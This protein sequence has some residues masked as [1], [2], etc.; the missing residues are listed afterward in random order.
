MP[1]VTPG[2]SSSGLT[3]GFIA[4]TFTGAG[5]LWWLGGG[6]GAAGAAVVML[7]Y[8]VFVG[9]RVRWRFGEDASDSLYFLG[10]LL[11][12]S[13]LALSFLA[14]AQSTRTTLATVLAS[15]GHGLLLTVWGLFLR[16]CA[17]LSS[18]GA[19]GIAARAPA[20]G[21]ELPAGGVLHATLSATFDK[22]R[23]AATAATTETLEAVRRVREVT[24]ELA[25]VA[26]SLGAAG[27]T[28]RESTGT[29]V[30][31]VDES[32]R[33]LAESSRHAAAAIAAAANDVAS[34]LGDGMG[35]VTGAADEQT[36][37][38]A[39]GLAR[40]SQLGERATAIALSATAA[41]EESAKLLASRAA[42]IPDPSEPARRYSETLH[43][44]T[45]AIE[46]AGGGAADAAGLVAMNV[47]AL[48]RGMRAMSEEASGV[49][50]AAGA[51]LAKTRAHFE[52]FQE[53]EREYVQLVEEVA[54]RARRVGA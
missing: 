49:V 11:T 20:P 9:V 25:A 36:R 13:L 37:S 19:H 27:Q 21:V 24:L 10:F 41:M 14:P 7:G 44:L 48:G 1:P 45:G 5:A 16:Q 43:Q 47:S 38:A 33:H 35:R 52:L 17:M 29:L 8:F 2:P 42:A 46:R 30:A 31:A 39:E 50:E 53:L 32:A 22:E 4:A 12:V 6:M 51:A 34:S 18:A 3:A 23:L 40:L 15:V 54:R 26:S 28:I